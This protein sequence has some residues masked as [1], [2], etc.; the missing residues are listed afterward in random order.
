MADILKFTDTIIID[1]SIQEYECHEYDTITG[2]NLNIGDDIRIS[3]E[4]QRLMVL[5]TPMQMRLL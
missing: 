4:S 1:E 3:I 2:I 5:I